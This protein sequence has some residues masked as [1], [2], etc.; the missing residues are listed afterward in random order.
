MEKLSMHG[1]A[2]RL[3]VLGL[4][5]TA[6]LLAPSRS[7]ACKCAPPPA[8]PEALQQASAVF[9]GNVTQV[10]PAEEVL[11]VTLRVTRA[12]KGISTETVRVRTRKDTAAC[13]VAFETGRSYVV[14]ANQSAAADSAIPL[15]VLRCGRTRLAEE[16]DEDLA[17]LGL[18]VVPVAARDP[19]PAATADT[20]SAPAQ[21]P[22]IDPAAGGCAGCGVAGTRGGAWPLAWL[23]LALILWRARFSL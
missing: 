4:A 20:G 22:A 11:E 9:E 17:Q 12:W 14:Y 16:S 7:F 5:G 21:P 6:L 1:L 19:A 2:G 13:G 3:L 10:A 18:G 8:V 23:W 15:E